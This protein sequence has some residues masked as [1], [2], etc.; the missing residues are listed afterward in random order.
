MLSASKFSSIC[1]KFPQTLHELKPSSFFLPE[2][3]FSFMINCHIHRECSGTRS[4]ILH[5]QQMSISN[6]ASDGAKR[7][8]TGNSQRWILPSRRR[9][10]RHRGSMVM[11]RPHLGS[12]RLRF[13]VELETRVRDRRL[14]RKAGLQG[15]HRDA[16]RHTNPNRPPR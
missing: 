9:N 16:S 11:E 1:L 10:P 15:R 12:N 6:M 3:F 7:R 14:R 8:P 4:H 5:P 2:F 13:P